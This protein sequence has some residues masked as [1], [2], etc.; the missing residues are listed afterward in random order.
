MF[1]Y[2][3]ELEYYLYTS[4]QKLILDVLRTIALLYSRGRKRIYRQRR[5]L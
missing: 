3:I 4:I 1:F 2:R 5:K